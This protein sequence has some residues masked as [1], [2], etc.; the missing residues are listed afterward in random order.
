MK[1]AVILNNIG[2]PDGP[3][4]RSVRVYL[5]EFLM[6]PGVIELPYV[7]RFIL[8]YLII[9]PFRA[10]KSAEK[11]KKIWQPQGSP[12]VSMTRSIAQKMRAACD[13]I[14]VETGM[15]FQ[16]PSIKTAIQKLLDE[17]PDLEKLYFIPMYPQFSA[18]TTEASLKKFREIWNRYFHHY[19]SIQLYAMRPFYDCDFFINPYVEKI[20]KQDLTRYDAILFSYHGLPQKAILKNPHCQLNN[21]CCDQGLK[22]NCYRSQCMATTRAILKALD[23]GL[24]AHT[25]FQSRLGR[26]EWIRPYTDE[27]IIELVHAG[28]KRILVLSPAFTVDCLE[29]LEEIQIELRGLFLTHGGEVFDYVP[30][31]NDDSS[32]CRDLSLLVESEK[33]F[34]R[35]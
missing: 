28:V 24:A 22:N 27:K 34:D 30:C 12:L 35:L 11:Y 18:A 29:T 6:D 13:T 17:N 21:H 5:R 19:K 31:L 3:D 9:T 10:A 7:F 1:K 32:W 15:I 2:S 20:K 26:G 16:N 8:V 4:T 23:T 14:A 25:T 33:H